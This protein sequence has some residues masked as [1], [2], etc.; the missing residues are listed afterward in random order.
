MDLGCKDDFFNRQIIRYSKSII[1]RMKILMAPLDWGLGHTTRIIPLVRAKRAAGNEVV[2]ACSPSQESQ[3]KEH[4]PDLRLLSNLPAYSPSYNDRFPMSVNLLLQLKRLLKTISAEHEWLMQCE[5]KEGFDHIISDHR[6]GL[7]HPSVRSSIVAHQL[8]I[9]G[10]KMIMGAVNRIQASFMNRFSECL[11]PDDPEQRLSGIL[12]STYYLKIP[13]SYIGPLSRFTRAIPRPDA[14]RYQW[15]VLISGPDP[16][17]KRF[18]HRLLE[19]FLPLDISVIIVSGDPTNASKSIRGSV[20]VVSHLGDADLEQTV[21]LSRNILCRSGY[22]TIMDLAVWKRRAL[23]IP[24]AGQTEQEYLAQ[25]HSREHF[26]LTCSEDDLNREV[27]FQADDAF[28]HASSDAIRI[29]F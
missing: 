13:C 2:L 23:L 11:I 28:S 29:D 25:W 24:T 18:L 7:Y 10:P 4:F 6:Y 1:N 27:L 20:T 5:T 3:L 26:H 8:Q 19:L 12:S 22:S 15:C 17:R 21:A 16:K 14:A 9:Q